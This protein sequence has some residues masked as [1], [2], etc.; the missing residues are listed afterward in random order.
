MTKVKKIIVVFWDLL[1]AIT[2][3]PCGSYEKMLSNVA[4]PMK[5]KLTIQN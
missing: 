3:V 2:Y 4:R 1:S 5:E